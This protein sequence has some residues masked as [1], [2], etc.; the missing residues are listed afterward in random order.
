LF[1]LKEGHDD[2][3]A[4]VAAGGDLRDASKWQYDDR[5]ARPTW[6][7]IVRW[8]SY[9]LDRSD[10]APITRKVWKSILPRIAVVM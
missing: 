6:H 8:A 4:W 2:T 10:P 9:I 1:V 3:G 5:D 7:R